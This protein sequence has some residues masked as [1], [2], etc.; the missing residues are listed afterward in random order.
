MSTN[1]R[2]ITCLPLR[3]P[4]DHGGP[5][6]R[7]AGRVRTTLDSCLVRVELENG[8][9]GWGESYGAQLDAVAAIFAGRIAPLAVGRDATDRSLTSTLERT[10]HNMGRSGPVIH[11]LGGLDI[12][13]WDSRAK[14]EGVPLYRLLGGARRLD[15]PAYASLLQYDG[16][17][18]LIRRNVERSLRAGYGQV[19]LHERTTESVAAARAAM[20]PETV[21]MVDTNCAWTAD[22]A[23]EAVRAMAPFD[24]FW[25]EEP[26]WPPED[27]GALKALRAAT[28]IPT[29]VGEN[30][31]SLH[32]LRQLVADEAVDYL[33]PSAIKA[34]GV[35]ALWQLS[36]DCADSRVRFA[37]QSAFFG[38]GFLATLHVL[39]AQEDDAVVERLYCD[40]A[41]SPYSR[42]IPFA[43]GAFRLTDLPG[44]GA[45]PADEDDL[46]A[47]V[48]RT[49]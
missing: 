36:R 17:T 6:P 48:H 35:S 9:V 8:V 40:L 43:N 37:P 47:F 19:K 5:A 32:E 46:V 49:S 14:L 4:F 44:L 15:I 31:S 29:A 7:F 34:G 3:L 2:S 21:L 26:L 25:I 45:D 16:D 24:P 12:A 42:S 38:P 23:T 1:I 13:L 27:I 41:F 20:G 11:A 30:A 22:T 18:E 28:G 39:A 33:Q 10:L